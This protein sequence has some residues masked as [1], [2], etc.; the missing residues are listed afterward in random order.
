MTA[1]SQLLNE[2]LLNHLETPGMEKKAADAISSYTRMKMREDGFMRPILPDVTIMNSELD[3]QADTPKPVKIVDK[4]PDSPAAVSVAFATLPTNTYIRG[5]R[6]SITFD[7]I[8]TNR[9]VVD[10]DEIRTWD[11][12]IRQI[13]SD[14]A[15]TEI[16]AEEDRKFLAA[17]N[18]GMIGPDVAVPYNS[19]KPLWVTLHGGIVR[20]TVTEAL[21]VMPRGYSRLVCETVLVNNVSVIDFLK[22]SREETGGDLSAEMLKSGQVVKDL[23]GKTWVITIKQDLVPE[24]TMY[25]F[26]GPKW[27]GKHLTLEPAKMYIKKEAFMVEFFLYQTS[28]ASIG[29]MSGCARIDFK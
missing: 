3:R 26:A 14:Q 5:A 28:G 12:D 24:D 21:K 15:T 7:R 23:L 19:D 18:T 4:E 25:Q 6:Y 8:M 10:V 2:T 1:D 16:L 9:F 22:W 13:V 11:M 27:L 20:N 29:N 17:V